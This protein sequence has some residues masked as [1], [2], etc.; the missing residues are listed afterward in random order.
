M[1]HSTP[2]PP[3]GRRLLHRKPAVAVVRNIN[4]SEPAASLAI[5]P[6][7]WPTTRFSP[8][9][10]AGPNAGNGVDVIPQLANFV[11]LAEGENDYGNLLK[12]RNCSLPFDKSKGQTA[13]LPKNGHPPHYM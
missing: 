11:F 8:V 7:D 10:G 2:R 4:E 12:P 13:H 5:L 9:K 1:Y 6:P 3:G